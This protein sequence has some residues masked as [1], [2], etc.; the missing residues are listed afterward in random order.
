MGSVKFIFPSM[1]GIG[2]VTDLIQRETQQDAKVAVGRS[3]G[4]A[5]FEGP[6]LPE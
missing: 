5:G 2:N 3:P 6:L 4:L 1:L